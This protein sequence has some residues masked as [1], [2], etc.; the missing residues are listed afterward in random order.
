LFFSTNNLYLDQAQT[1]NQDIILNINGLY[2][3]ARK[4]DRGAEEQLFKKLYES[5]SIFVQHRIWNK[6]DCEEIVQ[7]SL[8][9]IKDKYGNM[10]FEKSFSAWA[11]KVLE[12]K[13]LYFMRSRRYHENMYLQA[14]EYRQPHKLHSDPVFLRQLLDCLKKVSS[15]NM[16]HARILNMHYQGFSV[17]EICGKLK[18]TR[19]G[20]YI[21]L[22]RARSLLKLCLEKG[23]V[24]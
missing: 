15:K 18:L 8:M 23:D 11:Y 3:N 5:F 16:R 9:A 2:D 1:S 22:S 10:H 6:Q 12:N 14:S 17:N 4:G 13:I 24:V 20:M 7:D 19:N 21:L